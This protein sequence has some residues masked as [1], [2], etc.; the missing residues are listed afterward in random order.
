MGLTAMLVS[1]DGWEAL[2]IESNR[3]AAPPWRDLVTAPVLRSD[4]EAV[5]HA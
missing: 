5:R 4:C 2:Q 3:I 1:L